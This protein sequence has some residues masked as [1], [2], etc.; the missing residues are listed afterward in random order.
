MLF[1][2][3]G[4]G[5][6]NACSVWQLRKVAEPLVMTIFD[7]LGTLDGGNIVHSAPSPSGTLVNRKS[8]CR[9]AF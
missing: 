7:V 6:L 8:F 3:P 4:P 9:D 2:G 1:S 5:P